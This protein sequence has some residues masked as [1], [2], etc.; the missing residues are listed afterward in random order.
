M[1]ADY[2]IEDLKD[3]I[4]EPDNLRTVIDFVHP[5]TRRSLHMDETIEEVRKRYPGAVVMAFADWQAKKAARQDRPVEWTETTEEIY[6]EQL[7]CLPPACFANGGFLVG[8]PADHHAVSGQPRFQA[9]RVRDGKYFASSR[10]M[11]IEEF[12]NHDG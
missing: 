12:K 6:D 8:E 5:L 9:Y 7:G 10:A 2:K 4:V 3:A 11:T 1:I